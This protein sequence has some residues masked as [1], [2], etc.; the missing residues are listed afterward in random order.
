MESQFFV[1][2]KNQM[3][4]SITF[5]PLRTKIQQTQWEVIKS[6]AVVTSSEFEEQGH[7]RFCSSVTSLIITT[8]TGSNNC[9]KVI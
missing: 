3:S 4:N 7:K 1:R 5:L 6:D 2:K 9:W 8:T